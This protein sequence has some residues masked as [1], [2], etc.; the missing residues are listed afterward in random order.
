MSTTID[1]STFVEV[2]RDFATLPVG[3]Q[4]AA[5]QDCIEKFRN[6]RAQLV[7]EL[8]RLH[9]EL[10]GLLNPALLAGLITEKDH[11]TFQSTL[12]H[13]TSLEASVRKAGE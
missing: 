8:K 13:L 9:W 6:P 5:M 3:L 7:S 10:Q 12:Y 1:D 2:Q 11:L 4:R